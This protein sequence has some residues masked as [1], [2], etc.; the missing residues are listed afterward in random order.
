[1]MGKTYEHWR[2]IPARVTNNSEKDFWYL[3]PIDNHIVVVPPGETIEANVKVNYP[4][5]RI[6]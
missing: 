5:P 3:D 1:M 6:P 4:P 2:I